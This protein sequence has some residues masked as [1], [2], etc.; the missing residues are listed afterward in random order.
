MSKLYVLIPIT[1]G[2]GLI[3]TITFIFTILKITNLIKERENQTNENKK[4]KIDL[5]IISL[6]F[7]VVLL[8]AGF[9]VGGYTSFQLITEGTL[10][11]EI[12]PK[13]KTKSTY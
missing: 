1:L 13:Q 10:E 9:G 6:G 2:L 12:V 8:L 11:T 5:K 4:R 7:A 3:V